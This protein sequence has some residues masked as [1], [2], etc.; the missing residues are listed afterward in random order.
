MSLVGL[1]DLWKGPL[2]VADCVP[3]HLSFIEVHLQILSL[4]P[5]GASSPGGGKTVNKK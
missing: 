5:C 2:L 1:D 4:G 3:T